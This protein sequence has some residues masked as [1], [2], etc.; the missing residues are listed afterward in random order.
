MYV[1]WVVIVFPLAVSSFM[2]YCAVLIKVC[3][4]TLKVNVAK[5][6]LV[7]ATDETTLGFNSC[8]E[9]ESIKAEVIVTVDEPV[10]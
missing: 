7:I 8:A 3:P 1:A 10:F 9:Y 4:L 5:L 6:P 2:V